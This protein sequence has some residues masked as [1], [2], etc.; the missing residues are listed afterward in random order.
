MARD[1]ASEEREREKK[2]LNLL[3]QNVP[4][5][6]LLNNANGYHLQRERKKKRKRER[7]KHFKRAHL[8]P[9]K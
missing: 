8:T 9:S 5:N 7:E 2:D 3:L 6:G 4:R 1:D